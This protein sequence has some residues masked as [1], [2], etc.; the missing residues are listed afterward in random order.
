MGAA[1]QAD[2]YSPSYKYLCLLGYSLSF[3]IF[4]CGS[5]E[6]PPASS[7]LAVGAGHGLTDGSRC[8]CRSQVSILGPTIN[9][10][11]ER[12]GVTEPDLSPLFTALGVSCIISGT[13]SGWVVDRLPT[14]YVLIGSLVVE[15]RCGHAL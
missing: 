4:G 2:R 15:V 1:E 6:A 3:V 12:L 5:S 9:P 13:P 10:L 7:C 8:L 14:H 11:A